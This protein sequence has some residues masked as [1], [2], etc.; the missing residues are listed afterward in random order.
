[1]PRTRDCMRDRGARPARRRRGA[2]TRHLPER[3]RQDHAHRLSVHAGEA[4]RPHAG[5]GDDARPRRRL[6]EPLPRAATRRRRSRSGTGCGAR[7]GRRKGY[8]AVLVDGFGPRGYPAG[9]PRFS[10]DTRPDGGERGQ[11]APAR[12]LWRADLAAHAQR[13]RRRPHRPARLVERRQRRARNHGRGHRALRR[14]HRSRASTP[15]WCSI[16]PAGCAAGSTTAIGPTRRCASFT[17]PPTRKCRTGAAARWS[18]AAA[19]SAATSRSRSIPARPTASTIPAGHGREIPANR[20]AKEDATARALSFLRGTPDGALE[21]SAS[22]F[23]RQSHRPQSGWPEE[24]TTRGRMCGRNRGCGS[25][26]LSS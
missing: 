9:F 15:R 10:Y 13:R 6:F 22:P 21:V 7:C 19:S 18:S 25:P 1:M 16:R 11:R 23:G 8:V 20:E 2:E 4:R 5:G 12:C 26:E 3:R 24:P 17:A 14:R